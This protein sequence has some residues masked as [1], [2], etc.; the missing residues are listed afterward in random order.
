MDATRVLFLSI[1]FSPQVGGVERVTA[2]LL[3]ALRE[4][5][6]EFLV[7]V[8]KLQD[9]PQNLPLEA[10]VG[11]IHVVRLPFWMGHRNIDEMM[12]L[13][14][15]MREIKRSFSPA[16]VHANALGAADFFHSITARDS[17][18][19]T[20]T[21]LHGEWPGRFEP[22]LGDVL[23]AADWITVP[24]QATAHYA[25][26]IAPEMRDR[27]SVVQNASIVSSDPTCPIP[28]DVPR[29]LFVG[30]LSSEKGC[31]LALTA[32]QQVRE[33]HPR[34]RLTV[35]GDGPA[36]RELENLANRL[37]VQDGVDFLGEVPP[38]CVASLLDAS[39]LVIVPS[40]LE[41]FGLVALEAAH[42]GRPVVATRV[43]GLPEV[44]V[45]RETGIVVEPEAPSAIAR[46]VV[47]LL[48]NH[49]EAEKM[50][51]CAQRRAARDFGWQGFVGS[52]ER[53]YRT[54]IAGD[55]HSPQPKAIKYGR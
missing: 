18:A 26:R 17:Q 40:R 30:R 49:P 45:H 38:T 39:T 50:G 12:T 23:R 55:P 13:R 4:R 51:Q 52:Y 24:S 21:T 42:R 8:P 37:G 32:L 6:F 35:A 9:D 48:E 28:L 46:A 14:K 34:A 31:D 10:V 22:L 7:V 44:V 19:P 29:L 41:G 47:E 15:R 53:L 2:E 27:L 33:R 5:G 43:G 54:L 36:R 16:L 20:L 3:P 1:A 25:L 11:E